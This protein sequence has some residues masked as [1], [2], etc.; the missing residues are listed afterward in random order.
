MRILIPLVAAFLAIASGTAGAAPPDPLFDADPFALETMA[1]KPQTDPAL[2]DYLKGAVAAGRLDDRTADTLLRAAGNDP[3]ASPLLAVRALALAGQVALRTG[4]YNDAATLLDRAISEHDTVLDP[5]L[6]ADMEQARGLAMALRDT[7]AESVAR[8]GSGTLRLSADM[9]GLTTAPVRI[10]GKP[11]EA[12]LDTGANLST[13]SA[14]AAKALGVQMLSRDTAVHSSTSNA[15]QTKLA[16]AHTL[17]F[18]PVV[19]HD[20]VFLVVDDAAL[21]PLGPKSRI[22]VIVGFPVLSTLG[23]LTFREHD[24]GRHAKVRELA[25]APSPRAGAPGNLRFDAFSPFVQLSAGGSTLAFFLDSG[26]NKTVFEKRYGREHLEQLAGLARKSMHVGG[27]GVV[28]VRNEAVFPQLAFTIGGTALT[29]PDI[30]VELD[31]NGSDTT[32]GT[33]GS[34]VLWAKGGYTLDFGRLT[35]SLGSAR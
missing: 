10:D 35:L 33:L 15:V 8:R 27:A 3:K 4:R 23:R 13:L 1:A 25:I 28:E 12:V 21:S 22:D 2:R 30:H 11:Q 29:V 17:V 6:R 18:G 32:Y 5:V 14:S 34:D 31:G 7:P 20:V 24:T 19:L 9:L 16:I 26:A